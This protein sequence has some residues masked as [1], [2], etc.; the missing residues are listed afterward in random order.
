MR[1]C[2]VCDE[3]IL[4]GEPRAYVSGLLVHSY[5]NPDVDGDMCDTEGC[6]Y[7]WTYHNGTCVT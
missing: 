3:P 7:R 2:Y 1:F 4:K 6:M 5:C